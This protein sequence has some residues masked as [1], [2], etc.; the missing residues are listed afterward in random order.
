MERLPQKYPQFNKKKI[1]YKSSLWQIDMMIVYQSSANLFCT[2][3]KIKTF[4]LNLKSLM[5]FKQCCVLKELQIGCSI[6]FKYD[7]E[8][9][10]DK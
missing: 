6:Y 9:K 1:Y 3:P 5:W 8:S 10:I 4:F 2:P 7:L